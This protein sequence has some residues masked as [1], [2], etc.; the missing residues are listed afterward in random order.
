MGGCASRENPTMQE[1]RERLERE[2]DAAQR[3]A[4]ESAE[5]AQRVERERQ[6]AAQHARQCQED[7]RRRE[8]EARR[9]RER[10]KAAEREKQ[11]SDENARRFQQEANQRA[12][13]AR[14]ARERADKAAQEKRGAEE[15]AR[16]F[17]E[18]AE[19]QKQ[20]AQKARDDLRRGAHPD[21]WPTLEQF[22]STKERYGYTPDMV[23]IAIA[24]IS[25]CGK[26][27]LVN[28]F[29]GLTPKDAK[30]AKTGIVETTTEVTSYPDPDSSKPILWFDVPGAGT[31]NVS[32]WEY[33]NDQGL[34]IFDAIVVV[35]ADRFCATD[36]AILKAAKKY[37]IPAYI[38][39]SKSDQYIRN[40]MEEDEDEDEDE[41]VRLESACVEYAE[42]TRR[43]VKDNLARAGL[44]DQDIFLISRAALLTIVAK[45]RKAPNAVILDE[46][47]LVKE[48]VGDGIRRRF[49]QT[50][51]LASVLSQ[52]RSLTN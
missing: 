28:S 15:H 21:V 13:E 18:E 49:R 23:H 33:F 45:K 22:E 17:R 50:S 8:E 5:R 2:R 27:S 48:M 44:A 12:E 19:R 30:A 34:F 39:R 52:I 10:T 14:I 26:S 31:L 35:F 38:V 11:A 9:A 37:C 51:A 20:E 3:S 1:I 41:E 24:G 46:A 32:D 36:V 16:R 7:A 25:G 6:A 40:M 47:R 29:R 43:N 4:A 42:T